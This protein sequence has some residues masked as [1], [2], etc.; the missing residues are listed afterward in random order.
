MIFSRF[1]GFPFGTA[2]KPLKRLN[3]IS[4]SIFSPG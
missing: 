3:L 1:N 2:T 4:A